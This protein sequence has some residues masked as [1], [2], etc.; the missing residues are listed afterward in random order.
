MHNL[1]FTFS[2]SEDKERYND[3]N[4]LENFNV[5]YESGYVVCYCLTLDM[6]ICQ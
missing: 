1:F 5:L 6:E 4:K 3:I 2:V